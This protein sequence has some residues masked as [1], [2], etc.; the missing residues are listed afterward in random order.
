[1]KKYSR[2]LVPVMF[3]VLFHLGAN[4]QKIT[5]FAGNGTEGYSGDKGKALAAKL[6]WPQAVTLDKVGRLLIADSKNNVIR[7]VS[8]SGDITTIA[9]TGFLAGSGD[10]DYSGDSSAA[11]LAHLFTPTGVATDTAGNIFIAD[12]DNSRIRKIDT[13]GKIYTISGNGT[14][15]YGGDGLPATAGKFVKP[16]RVATD[17]FGNIYIADPQSNRIRKINAAG[18]ISTFAGTGAPTY[19][20]DGGPAT[21]ATL[22]YP[23]DVA[24]DDS[25]NVYIADRLNNCIRKVDA[26]GIIT[27]IAGTGIPAF[28]GDGGPATAAR[29]YDPTGVAVDDS[30]NVFFSDNG[31]FRI[32]KVSRATG[33]ISTVAGADTSGYSGDGGPATAAK[34]WFPQGVVINP[35]GSIYIADMGNNRIRFVGSKTEG[36]TTVDAGFAGVTVYPNPGQ[37][38]FTMNISSLFSEQVNVLI[39]NIAGEKVYESQLYTNKPKEIQL[40]GPPGIYF[41]SAASAHGRWAGRLIT[42]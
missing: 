29:I 23:Y 38:I 42:R 26:T 40:Y 33:Y 34:I 24:A 11:T 14:S 4:G 22:F 32:R 9:G 21:A 37:G 25:G 41:I 31:N 1:M 2:I 15:A 19:T 20:G 13:S 36:V 18:T 16:T 30:G 8:I 5:T 17:T 6:H 35:K 12:M 39:S 10:G 7:R 28:T 27:T 3:I